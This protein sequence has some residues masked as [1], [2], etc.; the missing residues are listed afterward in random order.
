M[1]CMISLQAIANSLFSA[2]IWVLT[3]S[4][5]DFVDNVFIAKM[6]VF[7]ILI[8]ILQPNINYL[9]NSIRIHSTWSPNTVSGDLENQKWNQTLFVIL[10][11]K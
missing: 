7:D 5:Y 8:R 6:A 3:K 4:L 1:W 11:M 10:I 2:K 9:I